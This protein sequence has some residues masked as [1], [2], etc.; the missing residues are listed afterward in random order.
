MAGALPPS[1]KETFVIFGA[2]A[3]IVCWPAATLPVK[4]TIPTL[5][6]AASS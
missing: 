5:G 3:N 4:L 1:S 2:A 6:L